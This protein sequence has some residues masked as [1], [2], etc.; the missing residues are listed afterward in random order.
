MGRWC[1][2]GVR[3]FAGS[4]PSTPLR[5]SRPVGI[6]DPHLYLILDSDCGFKLSLK[7]SI[8]EIAAQVLRHYGCLILPMII[9]ILI[10][11]LAD[12]LTNTSH[13]TQSTE[14]FTTHSI[15]INSSKHNQT[16]YLPLLSIL[17]GFKSVS[18]YSFL[19]L[20]PLS[21]SIFLK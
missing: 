5:A 17:S 12:Q 9:S 1:Y 16:F 20:I 13:D 10:S 7:P 8:S 19:L 3:W 11:S 2:E 18:I 4:S 6:S 14:L 15:D 21:H